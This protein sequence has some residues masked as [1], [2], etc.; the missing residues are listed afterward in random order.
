MGALNNRAGTRPAPT[1]I[2]YR[3]GENYKIK[4]LYEKNDID[5]DRPSRI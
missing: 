3:H 5:F 2:V 1:N 4:C